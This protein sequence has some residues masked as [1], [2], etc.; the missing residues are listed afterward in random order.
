MT[1]PIKPYQYVLGIALATPPRLTSVLT[2]AKLRGP[3]NVRGRLNGIGGRVRPGESP[4]AAMAREADEEAG[5]TTRSDEWLS[6]G[7]LA[8]DDYEVHLFALRYDELA[9]GGKTGDQSPTD[10]IVTWQRVASV[11]DPERSG[12][13][14]VDNLTVII[15]CARLALLDVPDG[16]RVWMSLVYTSDGV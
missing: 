5:L 3:P 13:A 9:H 11:T 6:F 15:A 14:V 1:T 2:I 16:D 8:G 4:P 7:T 12:V 10:E